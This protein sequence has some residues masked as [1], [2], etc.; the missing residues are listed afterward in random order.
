MGLLHWLETGSWSVPDAPETTEQRE[1]QSV[2]TDLGVAYE[3]KIAEILGLSDS[4]IPAVYRATQFIA[5]TLASLHME[6]V[7]ERSNVRDL[8]TPMILLRPDPTET[9]HE[10][11]HKIAMSLLWRG[12]AYFR[13]VSRSEASGLPT[14]IQVLNP[15]EVAVNWDRQRLFPV[16]EWRNQTL[17]RNRD[18]FHIPINLYP[19]HVE[20]MS[21]ISAARHLW[22]TMK[23]EGNMA[24]T[25]VADN[26]TPS[27]LLHSQKPLTRQE[28][29]EVRD[30]W[31][32]SHKGRKRVGVTSGTVE[33]KPLQ[34]KP[35]DA[36]FVESRNFSIQEVARIFGLPG[37]FL[38]VSSGSSMTYSTTESLN[39]LFV[40]NTL[41]PTYLE[42]I[43]QVFSM[44]LPPFKVARFNTDE[45]LR[46]DIKS[47]YEAHHIGIAAG[48]KTPN[49]V[50]KEEG[51]PPM[52]G[53]DELRQ[54]NEKSVPVSQE[55]KRA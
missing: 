34:I 27:G 9:Y 23:A 41:R 44:L 17:E 40:T 42:R 10:T 29:E 31:E 37:H 1:L 39:R 36:Q 48:F 20:G 50:R 12:N 30:I 2:V 15:D 8:D 46:A 28:A 16:Y 33:F 32:G 45:L 7:D 25:L 11:M 52:L 35:V 24:K 54:P 14:A 5:D 51:L 47:R 6:Q 21:P 19:G 55:S 22:E 49:E 4:S 18:I 3:T 13:V 53:G 38:G 43:E 26:A